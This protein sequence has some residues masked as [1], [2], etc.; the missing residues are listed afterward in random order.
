MATATT[1]TF[2]VRG[3]HCSGCSDNLA[4]ALERLEGVI[5]VRGDYD[6]A[7]VEVRYDPDRVTEDDLRERIRASGFEPE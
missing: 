7:T 2:R 3:F 5:R 4:K 6:T 1:T